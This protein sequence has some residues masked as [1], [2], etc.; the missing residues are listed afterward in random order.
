MRKKEQ[1]VNTLT[2]SDKRNIQN[3]LELRTKISQGINLL[4]LY[5]HDNSSKLAVSLC[6]FLAKKI[7]SLTR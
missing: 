5:L 2:S 6:S 1:K 7:L 4:K 3:C